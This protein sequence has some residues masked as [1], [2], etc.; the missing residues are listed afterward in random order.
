MSELKNIKL[1]IAY[2]GTD[3]SGWQRQN[4]KK[5]IQGIIEDELRNLTGEKELKLYGSGRTDAGVHAIGQVANF[6]TL[7]NIPINKLSFALNNL[8]PGDIRIKYA[9]EVHS[10][11]HARYNAKSRVYRYNIIN[12]AKKP[13]IYKA[14]DLFLSRYC[15]YCN[16]L[17]NIRIMKDTAQY[18]LGLN[19][20][21][22]FSCSNQ[23]EITMTKNKIREIKKIVITEKDSLII[24]TVEAD[25]FL[26]KMVRKIIGT[27]I[28]FSFTN[29]DPRDILEM[30]RDK[31]NQKS[32]RVMPPNGL[33]LVKVRY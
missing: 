13:V 14:K 28:E 5:T 11:F 3:Y 24:F 9:R 16:R 29:R 31:N 4:N 22:S 25:A 17:L 15:Y 27:L 20:F 26:Y 12:R 19:D 7:S 8:L 21:S 18:L 1:T 32:G 33:F 30:L 10:N 6:K 23:K 2:D